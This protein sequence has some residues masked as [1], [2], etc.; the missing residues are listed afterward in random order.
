MKRFYQD[1]TLGLEGGADVVLLDGR[2]IRTPGRALMAMPVHGLA[3]AVAAEWA[4][5]GEAILPDTMPLTRLVTTVID[6]M[7]ARRLD[8][9][10]EITGYCETDLL[11]Y[12]QATPASLAARQRQAWQPWLD[13]AQSELGARLL[14]TEHAM[15]QMQPQESLDR[16][17]A[18]V[19]V[20]DHWRLVGLHAAVNLTGSLVLGLAIERS[21]LQAAQAFEAAHLD[22]L[23]EIERWGPDPEVALRHARVRRDL[24]AACTY[25][26]MLP[27]AAPA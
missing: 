20:L 23:F 10:A 6:L 14:A 17:A 16:L 7:P 9:I 3:R 5:Q 11:C 15:P 12:R 27:Q 19:Q 4:A 25:L 1:V 8:A 24:E 13:W 22:E 2:P 18:A 21:R 26:A